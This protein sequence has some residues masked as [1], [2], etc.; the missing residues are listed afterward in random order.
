MK[1]VFLEIP[2][3]S[4]E[5]SCARVSVLMK[6]QALGLRFA[7][8]LEKRLWHM[9]FPVSFVKFVRTPFLQN[10][11]GRLLIHLPSCDGN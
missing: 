11:S 2:Q 8:L 5:C 6:L 3:N 9:C 10:L 4:Q 7:T 1:N